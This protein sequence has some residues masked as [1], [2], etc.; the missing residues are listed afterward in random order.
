M[1]I[2]GRRRPII[3]A[4]CCFKVMSSTSSNGNVS[5]HA[6]VYLFWELMEAESSWLLRAKAQDRKVNLSV[7]YVLSRLGQIDTFVVDMSRLLSDCPLELQLGMSEM[8]DEE[9]AELSVSR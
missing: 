3:I 4:V 2:A 5:I 6:S 8:G 1:S 7:S 9:A